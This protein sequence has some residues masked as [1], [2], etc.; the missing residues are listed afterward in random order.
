MT[1]CSGRN[2]EG[3][4]AT[5]LGPAREAVALTQLVPGI[6]ATAAA[7]PVVEGH[8]ER[9]V[10]VGLFRRRQSAGC[11]GEDD[12][13]SDRGLGE[14]GRISCLSCHSHLRGVRAYIALWMRGVNQPDVLP[15]RSL[16]RP[17]GCGKAL[18]AMH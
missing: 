17:A 2:G 13:E 9:R 4:K 18:W 16:K 6:A 8:V 1:A 3:L 7:P 15:N 14:H 11:G 12:R 5:S 10:G